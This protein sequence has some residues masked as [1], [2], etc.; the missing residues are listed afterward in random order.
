MGCCLSNSAKA[1]TVV[2][3][4]LST[5]I[6]QKI[7]WNKSFIRNL[8]FTG[9]YYWK[10]SLPTTLYYY[11]HVLFVFLYPILFTVAIVQLILNDYLLLLSSSLVGYLVISI[12]INVFIN[13]RNKNILDSPISIILY[14]LLFQWLIFYS[15]ITINRRDWKREISEGR[16]NE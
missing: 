9:K 15:I 2:P 10:R 3:D 1:W 12:L 13:A 5:I 7:R 6:S 14:H 8:F 11:L 16:Y 4:K